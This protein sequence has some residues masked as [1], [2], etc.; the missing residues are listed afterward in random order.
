MILN[1]DILHFN[2]R[3]FLA[4]DKANIVTRK[5]ELKEPSHITRAL[6]VGRTRHIGGKSL[7]NVHLYHRP[8]PACSG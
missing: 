2:Y 5:A 1:I 7:V 3:H 4:T 8:S 6:L